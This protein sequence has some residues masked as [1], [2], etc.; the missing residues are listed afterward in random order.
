MSVEEAVGSLKAHE[1][2]LKEKVEQKE[3]QLML[4]EEE[5][6]KCEG[7]EGKL[8]L[9]HEEWLR[10]SNRGGVDSTSSFK[11]RGS[12]DKSKIRCYNCD[13]YG[14]FAYD[15]RKPKRSKEQRQE[16][17]IAQ[18]ED[19]EPALLLAKYEKNK[20]SLM[21][22]DENRVVPALLSEGEDKVSESNLWY[23][24]NGAGNHMTGFKAKYSVLDEGVTRQVRFGDGSTVKSKERVQ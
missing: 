15:C 9:T 21:L 23:L 10:K 24:D 7:G 19:D 3:N 18:V 1:E 11:G 6:T 16:A 20:S 2:R 5:W 4:T 8:L 12:R 14:H 17:N 13:I 22:V